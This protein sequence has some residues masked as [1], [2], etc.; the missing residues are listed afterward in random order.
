MTVKKSSPFSRNL[1]NKLV[2]PMILGAAFT[3]VLYSVIHLGPFQG[4]SMLRYLIGHPVEYVEVAMFMVGVGA[5][6]L[7]GGQILSDFRG[8]DQVSLPE[9]PPGRMPISEA[10]NLLADLR[11][12]P[13]RFHNL[14]IHRRLSSVLEHVEAAE[15]ASGLQEE[16]KYLSDIDAERAEHDYSLVRIVIWATPMLGFLGTV[17][18]ITLA[19]GN[20]SPEALV[21]EPKVAMESLLQGLSVAFDTT[22]LALTLSIVLMFGQFLLAR[23]EAEQLTMIDQAASDQLLGRFQVDGSQTDP[24]VAAIRRMSEKTISTTQDLVLRQTELW[25]ETV[26]V[27]HQH[28]QRVMGSSQEQIET[29]IREALTQSLKTHAEHLAAAEQQ[30]IESR[31]QE[32]QAFT[33]TLQ[34]LTE[35][36]REQQDKL[37]EQGE[38]M[39][40]V[41]EATGEVTNLEESLNRNLK[42]LS[43]SHH[44][45]ETVSN[46]A[47]T[48]HLLNSRMGSAHE[49]RSLGRKDE[50]GHAA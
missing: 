24:N 40:R 25:R 42:A 45:E 27:A 14:L 8:A 43:G 1:S 22:A 48:I 11:E 3:T 7:K 4:W 15:T 21:N 16:L 47:A 44:F 41:V 19:L 39:L 49:S 36:M 10:P 18:G 34:T 12:M 31:Q 6:L 28:W 30:T 13:A 20:L 33:D 26:S 23:V 38:V 50:K 37:S 5:L 2:W 17:I 9:I 32:W 46:L 29:G 35:A